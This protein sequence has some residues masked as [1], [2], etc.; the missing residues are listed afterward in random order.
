MRSRWKIHL[1]SHLHLCKW[2][3]TI[4]DIFALVDS[5]ATGD[6]INQDLVKKKGYQLQRLFQPLKAQNV[7]RSANQ[8]GIIC[9]KVT[10]YLQIA[11][12]KEK[13]EFLVVNCDQENLILGLPWFQE[14]NL[15]IYW[16]TGEV[17]ISFIPR[18]PQHDF[19]A[20]IT[21]WYLICYLGMDPDDKIA[22][23]WKKR[24]DRYIKEAYPIRKTMLATELAQQTEKPKAK[25]P[26]LYTNF[27]DI[28]QKKTI[29]KL[30]PSRTFDHVIKLNKVF[31]PKVAKV[32]PLN[33]KE[34]ETCR[35]FVNKH[36]K[37]RKIVPSTSPQASPFFFVP[38][39][40]GLV[41]P[42]QDY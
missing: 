35:A 24:M 20:T 4:I 8:G 21:Q 31:S 15:L 14:I 29:D 2:R 1:Y 17:T 26:Q 7:D 9:H 12:T 13:R 32:Y 30:S 5:G 39:K 40:D 36:L 22:H 19:P 38:K 41:R 6:C 33:P 11:K 16:T 34:Q 27:R 28:F 3:S 25:L 10:L 23:L 18:T 37:S 42:C